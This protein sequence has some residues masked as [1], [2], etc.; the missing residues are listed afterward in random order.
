MSART[1]QISN[2]NAVYDLVRGVAALLVFLAHL[3]PLLTIVADAHFRIDIM[4]TLAFISV[5]FFF[6]LSGILLGPILYRHFLKDNPFQQVKIF[7]QRRWYR[8]LPA[9]YGGLIAWSVTHYL[10]GVYNPGEIAAFVPSYFFFV[11]NLWGQ[12]DQFYQI[13]W[14]I[15]IEELFYV[16]FTVCVAGAFFVGKRSAAHSFQLAIGGL[17]I[18]S[19]VMRMV[20]LQDFESWDSDIRQASLLRLDSIAMGALVGIYYNKIRAAVFAGAI[21]I[22]LAAIWY[23]SLYWHDIQPGLRE[24]IIL[25]ALFIL[26]PL[27]AAVIIKYLGEHWHLCPHPVIR[28][29]ADIS[30]PLYIFHMVIMVVYFKSIGMV[31]SFSTIGGDIAVTFLL[32]FAFFKC[33]ET[34]ILNRRPRYQTKDKEGV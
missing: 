8:T 18:F 9:F 30:Y 14:S 32:C 27:S 6:A 31:L 28:F 11:Q 5:E 4:D 13:A 23:I 12:H 22:V 24:G 16:V 19:L 7:L 26:L 20:Q 1:D 25:Q 34:P 33:V 3:Y 29:L 17:I 15:S 10:T 2:Y 21:F